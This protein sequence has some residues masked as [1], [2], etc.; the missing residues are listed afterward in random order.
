M[1]APGSLPSLSAALAAAS[2]PALT[3]AAFRT[4]TTDEG[5]EKTTATPKV[6]TDWAT[7]EKGLMDLNAAAKAA[8][9]TGVAT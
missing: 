2:D 8:A 3:V 4:D 1:T 5:F 9:P 6:W 7:F